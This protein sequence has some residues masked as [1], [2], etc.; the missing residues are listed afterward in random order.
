MSKQNNIPPP[1][2][3]APDWAMWRAQD[4]DGE[5]WWYERKPHPSEDKNKQW[6]EGSINGLMIRALNDDVNPNWR[7]TL[8]K[9]PDNE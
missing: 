8:E 9:R 7:N 5:W 6:L 3:E 4:E 1:W 2:S